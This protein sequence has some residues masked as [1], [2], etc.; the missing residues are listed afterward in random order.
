MFEEWKE[1]IIKA[2]FPNASKE[3]IRKMA[4]RNTKV[5]LMR[6]FE[7]NTNCISKAQ[8]KIMKLINH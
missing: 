8:L 1:K 2:K 4:Y 7:K 3:A 6:L 5:F